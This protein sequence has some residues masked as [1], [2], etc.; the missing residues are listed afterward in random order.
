MM[1]WRSLKLWT[2]EEKRIHQCLAEALQKL[3]HQHA[4][5]P[6]DDEKIITG[7]LRPIIIGIRKYRKLSW[8]VDFE[9]SVFNKTTD[10]NP[11]GHPDIHFTRLDK[12]KNQY[13]YHVECKLVRI[14][15]PGKTM[16]YCSQYVK[17]GVMRYQSGKYAQSNPPMGTML[18]YV[19]EG[20]CVALLNTVNKKAKQHDL[21]ELQVN[22]KIIVGGVTKL[23]QKLVMGRSK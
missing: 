10:A 4:V 2:D 23:S 18:G 7:N 16:D 12:D 1:F 19:Q 9:G 6:I 8:S 15:R 11:S 5:K 14:K 20:D 13:S 22:G 17:E 3:I 21:S